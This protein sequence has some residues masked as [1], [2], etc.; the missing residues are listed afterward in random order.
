MNDPSVDCFSLDNLV[1]H[2]VA[3][4]TYPADSWAGCSYRN[5]HFS[6][7]EGEESLTHDVGRTVH[8]D[9]QTETISVVDHRGNHSHN[10]T[11][12]DCLENLNLNSVLHG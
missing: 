11:D 12:F 8:L 7:E 3:M 6:K 5:Q 9:Y 10:L 4:V 1:L 2:S